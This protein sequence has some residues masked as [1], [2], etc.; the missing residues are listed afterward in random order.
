[1]QHS[2]AF[3]N[4]QTTPKILPE[5]PVCE[6]HLGGHESQGRVIQGT[7]TEK[8]PFLDDLFMRPAEK[9]STFQQ[10]TGTYP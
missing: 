4:G 8:T 3:I 7:I 9:H 10:G 5:G 2:P 1:M 6:A